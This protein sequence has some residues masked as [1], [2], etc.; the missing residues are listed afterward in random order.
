MK[1]TTFALPEFLPPTMWQVAH[2]LNFARGESLFL[3]GAPVDA[4]YFI[5]RGEVIA[6]RHLS[7]GAEAVIQRVSRGEFMGLSAVGDAEFSF[8]ARAVVDSEVA[9][10]PI[11]ELK[12]AL[13]RDGRFALDFAIHLARDLARQRTRIERL[14]IARSRDRVLHYLACEGSIAPRRIRLGD[15]ARDMGLAPETLSR[16][17]AELEAKGLIERQAKLIRLSGAGELLGACS[18]A[19][20]TRKPG[21]GKP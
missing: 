19:A 9:C 21:S 20:T 7:D 15:W 18:C 14:H 17:L 6:L 10:L 1:P 5:L 4:I 3:S 8:C 12:E 2:Q 11:A 13:R 16:C